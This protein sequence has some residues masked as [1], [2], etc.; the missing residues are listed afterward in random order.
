MKK[1]I[2]E[3]KDVEE[4]LETIVNSTGCKKAEALL[5]EIRENRKAWEDFFKEVE[6]LLDGDENEQER[7]EQESKT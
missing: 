2:W 4:L 6:E 3:I 7:R 1:W 5:E